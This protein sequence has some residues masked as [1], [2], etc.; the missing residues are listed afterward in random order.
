MYIARII[1]NRSKKPYLV[2]RE[3]FRN[4]KGKPTSRNVKKYGYINEGNE[5]ALYEKAKN[6]LDIL[7]SNIEKQTNIIV[8]FREQNSTSQPIKNLG[9]CI[10][11]QIYKALNIDTFIS[12]NTP[13]NIKS[14][15]V[16][17]ALKLLIYS[18]I[19]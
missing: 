7:N 4:A 19:L 17:D 2:I 1:D 10:L 9:Y 8:N 16:S 3:S 12:K 15:N 5:K 18:R 14:Y 13:N 11:E 6:D